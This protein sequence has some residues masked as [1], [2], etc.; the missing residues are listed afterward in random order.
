MRFLVL[1]ISVLLFSAGHAFAG[2]MKSAESRYY[3][4]HTDLAPD[5]AREAAIRMTRM[6]EEYHARTADFSGTIREKLLFFLFNQQDDYFQAGG[7]PGTAG[8]FNGQVLMACAYDHIDEQLWHTVQHEGFHQFARAVIG[9]QIPIWV[10]EGL[11]EYFG[12]AVFT[13]D[14]FVTG[15]IPQSRLERVRK[16][17]KENGFKSIRGMMTLSHAEWNNQMSMENYDQGWSMVHFLAHGDGGKYQ[18]AFSGFMIEIGRNV[19]WQTAWQNNFGDAVGFEEKWKAWWTTLPDNP[20]LDLYGKATAAT[21]TSYFARANA[22]KQT[23]DS[24]NE[25]VS[26]AAEGKLKLHPDDWLP[27]PLLIEALDRSQKVGE[28]TI[29]NQAGNKS[30]LLVLTMKDGTRIVGSFTVK[31]GGRVGTVSVDLDDLPKTLAEAKKLIQDGKKDQAKSKLRGSIQKNPN[32]P[33]LVEAQKVM[34]QIK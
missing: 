29:V 16:T 26:T 6:A 1:A 14:S 5:N 32:S 4:I 3:I 34:G 27:Q 10:N 20:T 22:Q 31:G 18:K 11:A 2:Q 25:F 9:G 19:K 13:G 12:E 28:W 8:V 17:I 21:L 33:S 30:P 23:F 15:V 24:Y 7:M